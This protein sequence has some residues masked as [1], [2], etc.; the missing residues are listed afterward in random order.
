MHVA[1]LPASDKL[2]MS[3]NNE[4]KLVSRQ[5]AGDREFLADPI[6]RHFGNH[7]H[8]ILDEVSIFISA[9]ELKC[10]SSLLDWS[11]VENDEIVS[12]FLERIETS[13]NGFSIR[14]PYFEALLSVKGLT[15]VA[16]QQ[17][18]RIEDQARVIEAEDLTQREPSDD[19]VKKEAQP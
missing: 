9:S 4:L 14:A 1:Y 7:I 17:F 15:C 12:S 13:Y 19:G 5:P 18:K 6:S 11:Q 10:L 8:G 16:I 3:H 2:L